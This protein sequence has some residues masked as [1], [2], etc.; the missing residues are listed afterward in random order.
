L[1][2]EIHGHAIET[3]SCIMNEIQ[4]HR[5]DL[6]LLVTFEALMEARSV[7]QA[8]RKLGKTPSAVSHALARLRDQLGDPLM[9]KVGGQMQPSPHALSLI[10]D[11]RPILRTIQRVVQPPEPFDPATST[12]SFRVAMITLPGLMARV[13][14]RVSALAPSVLLEWRQPDRRTHAQVL[15][16]LLDIA[17]HSSTTPQVEGVSRRVMDGIRIYCFARAGHPAIADWSR[18]QWLRWPHVLVDLGET[19]ATTVDQ[20]LVER[21]LERRVGARIPNFAVVAPLLAQSDLLS[22]NLAIALCDD[23]ERHDLRVLQIPT[24]DLDTSLAFSWS[25]RLANDPGSR[26]LRGIVMQSFDD[27]VREADARVAARGV[28]RPRE[29]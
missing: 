29:G 28:V 21:G 7:L 1:L 4:L 16:G 22:N 10:E 20:R 11:V 23:L 14:E 6:N 26:W 15:E 18:A 17:L 27:L 5:L 2:N 24:A 8:A 25:A 9:V 19:A 12:R 13:F 3:I